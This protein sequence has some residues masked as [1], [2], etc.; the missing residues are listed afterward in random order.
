[1]RRAVTVVE[2][3]MPFA[4]RSVIIRHQTPP[5]CLELA[6]Y[7]G[8]DYVSFVYLIANRQRLPRAFHMNRAVMDFLYDRRDK[9]AQRYNLYRIALTGEEVSIPPPGERGR[10][11]SSG[12]PTTGLDFDSVFGP[13][14][15][16]WNHLVR[17]SSPAS[18]SPPPRPSSTGT[19]FSRAYRTQ[20]AT[21]SSPRPGWSAPGSSRPAVATASTSSRRALSTAGGGNRR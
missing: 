15:D 9:L 18:R 14:V 7:G 5:C 1:M 3:L 13:S 6:T 17:S 12:I 16:Q 21:T 4:G 10:A 2:S 11:V 19:T 20:R 8:G